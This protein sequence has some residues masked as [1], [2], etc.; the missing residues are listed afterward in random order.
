M[1]K[2]VLSRLT[3]AGIWLF[4]RNA[5][6]DSDLIPYGMTEKNEHGDSKALRFVS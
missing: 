3:A 2:H 5:F 1:S 6:E 4:N